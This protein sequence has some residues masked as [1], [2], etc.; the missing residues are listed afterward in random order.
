[1]QQALLALDDVLDKLLRWSVIGCVAGCLFFLGIGVIGRMLA[2]NISSYPEFIEILF[3]WS[4]FLGAALLWRE[5]AL[6]RVD[7]VQHML[8][9]GPSWVLKIVIEL[10]MLIFAALM[11]YYGWDFATAI[12]EYTPFLQVDRIYWYLSIPVSAAIMAGYSVAA[13]YELLT[14]PLLGPPTESKQQE[15]L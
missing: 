14:H 9:A 3:A 5:R 7:F 6:L 1:M 12:K 4:T 2:F 10:G 11:V 13:L 15:I 8:P